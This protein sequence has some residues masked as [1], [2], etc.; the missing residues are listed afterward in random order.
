MVIEGSHDIK[1][2]KDADFKPAWD[3]AYKIKLDADGEADSYYK[4]HF[5][6]VE[7][8]QEGE[9]CGFK[10]V[11]SA[12][13]DNAWDHEVKRPLKIEGLGDLKTGDKITAAVSL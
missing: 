5:V 8:M 7:E 6:G 3:D 1:D 4:C 11:S 2:I 12:Y 10:Y 9:A 13:E